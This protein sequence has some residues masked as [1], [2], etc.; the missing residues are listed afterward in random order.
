MLLA[1]SIIAGII[2]ATA[3][4]NEGTADES[5]QNPILISSMD[6]LIE[7][8]EKDV[9]TGDDGFDTVRTILQ[10]LAACGLQRNA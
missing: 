7:E 3:T 2:P 10:S 4:A 9:D 5:T 1:L 8:M 6:Q